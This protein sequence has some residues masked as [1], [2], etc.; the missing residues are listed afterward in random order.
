MRCAHYHCSPLSEKSGL[1]AA[2]LVGSRNLLVRV[3]CGSSSVAAES[4]M[5]GSSDPSAASS[6]GHLPQGTK[7]NKDEEPRRERGLQKEGIDET[8][9]SAALWN[10]DLWVDVWRGKP[11]VED[12][13]PVL[14]ASA[15]HPASTVNFPVITQI[16]ERAADH[17]SEAQGAMRL[18]VSSF[19]DPAADARR[20]L[21]AL[22]IAHEMLF[23]AVALSLLQGEFRNAA[24]PALHKLKATTDS[25]VGKAVDDNIRL[26]ATEIERRCFGGEPPPPGGFRR[27]A[28][29]IG[30]LA[31]GGVGAVGNIAG[32]VVG[33][34]VDVLKQIPEL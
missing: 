19:T 12:S 23:D 24:V 11:V 2:V 8:L 33:G 20:K 1:Q 22:T 10:T 17:P 27:L 5:A 25:G 14:L 34:A 28:G 9:G 31:V 15:L 26:L 32:G 13:T 4:F 21:K 7:G 16:C 6:N 29:S 18:L 3:P 30:N